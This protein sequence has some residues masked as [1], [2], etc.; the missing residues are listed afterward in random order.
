M[1][2]ITKQEFLAYER[3]R[4]GGLTNMFDVRNVCNLSGLEKDKVFAI[5]KHYSELNKQFPGIRQREL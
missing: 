1:N 2:E 3:V 5:M 4:Q